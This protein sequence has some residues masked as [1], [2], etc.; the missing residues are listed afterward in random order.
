M[1]K[2]FTVLFFTAASIMFDVCDG[3][4]DRL[5]ERKD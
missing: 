5:I 1:A 2:H 4:E 3:E